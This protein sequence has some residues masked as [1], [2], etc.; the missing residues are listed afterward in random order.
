MKELYIY[1]TVHNHMH[2]YYL[3]YIVA[4]CRALY[5]ISQKPGFR[6]RATGALLA[7]LVTTALNREI[8]FQSPPGR[9]SRSTQTEAQI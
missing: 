2:I 3:C 5:K 8:G 6:G 4:A 9:D 7:D 1:N